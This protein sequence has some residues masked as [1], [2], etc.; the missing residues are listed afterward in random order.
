[1]HLPI[2]SKEMD[3][4]LPDDPLPGQIVEVPDGVDGGKV[5]HILVYEGDTLIGEAQQLIKVENVSRK[6]QLGRTHAASPIKPEARLRVRAITKHYASLIFVEYFGWTGFQY[7]K[8][9]TLLSD[10]MYE[11]LH[12]ATYFTVQDGPNI[13]ELICLNAID[14]G[15]NK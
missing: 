12:T 9:E 13:Y 15:E 10:R 7:K 8:E 3:N 2:G 11:V 6:W 4:Y 14:E 1:M 5:T